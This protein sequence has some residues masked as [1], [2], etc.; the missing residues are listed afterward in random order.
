MGPETDE[1]RRFREVEDAFLAVTERPEGEREG[2]LEGLDPAVREEVRRLLEAHDRGGRIPKDPR[3]TAFAAAMR[4]A[5]DAVDDA[6]DEVPARVGPYRVVRRIGRGGMGTVFEAEEDAPRRRVAVK[7]LRAGI[8][9]EEARRRFALEAQALARLSHPG[10]ARIYAMGTADESQGGRPWIAMELVTGRSILEH[11]RAAGLSVKARLGL[12]AAVADAVAHAHRKGV[13]HRDLKPGNVLVDEQG[14]PKVLDFGVARVL[15]PDG[16]TE[17]LHTAAGAL[18]GTVAYMSPE[19]CLGRADAIDTRSDVYALGALAYELLGGRPPHDVDDLAL[20]AAVREVAETDPPTLGAVLPTLKGDVSIL[21]AKAM[22]REP[23][24]RYAGADAFA[25]DVRRWLRE[26]PILARS[27]TAGY[28]IRKFVGR[29][30]ELAVGLAAAVLALVAGLVVA[31][32][33]GREE[34]RQ[35]VRADLVSTDA[36]RTRYRA[37][38]AAAAAALQSHDPVAARRRLE[39]VPADRR[40]WEWDWLWAQTDPA[41]THAAPAVD[42]KAVVSLDEDG[43]AVTGVTPAGEVVRLDAADGKRS[44]P[45]WPAGAASSVSGEGARVVAIGDDGRVRLLED[46]GRVREAAGIAPTRAR[47]SAGRSPDGTRLVVVHGDERTAGPLEVVDA[48]TG[49][50]VAT[51]SEPAFGTVLVR[52]SRDGRLVAT[53]G[54]ADNRLHVWEVETGRHVRA[55]VGHGQGVG[56]AAFSRDGRLVATGSDDHTAAVFAVDSGEMVVRLFGHT[57]PLTSVAWSPDEREVATAARD[58]TVRRY[59]ARRGEL[60]DTFLAGDVGDVL[61]VAW[62]AAGARIVAAGPRSIRAFRVRGGPPAVLRAHAGVDDGNPYPYVYG[63]AWSP[64]GRRVASAGWDGTAR[65][66]LAAT[67][68]LLA[69]FRSEDLPGADPAG[70]HPPYGRPAYGVAFSPDGGR[71]AVGTDASLVVYD[72]DTAEVLAARRTPV[73]GPGFGTRAPTAWS[74]DG[75]LLL[76]TDVG[77]VTQVADAA[78]LSPRWTAAFPPDVYGHGGGWSPDGT[79]VALAMSNGE[80]RVL[81]AEGG[82]EVLRVPA[83]EAR[84]GAERVANDALYVDGGRAIA[85][86]YADAAIRLFDATTGAL[87]ST[88]RGHAGAVHGLFASPDGLR[89]FSGSADGSIRV[90]DLEGAGDEVLS[91]GGHLSY[92]FS[93]ALS[94]DGHTLASGSGD[95]TVRL[96]STR[97]MWS[98]M[99]DARVAWRLRELLEGDAVDPTPASI[100]LARGLKMLSPKDLVR[101]ARAEEPLVGSHGAL[102]DWVLRHSPVGPR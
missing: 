86:S 22:A 41:A 49:A 24:R 63:V 42:L 4:E 58:G 35:R 91:M 37:E 36:V 67:G 55:I 72:A 100:T 39:L 1:A 66:C 16:G 51:G 46:G 54:P 83:P 14:Q 45:S 65:V 2:A 8:A 74:P 33:L 89:L 101:R 11:C 7:L 34:Q 21:V 95:G 5:L 26:E 84:P 30:K 13:I 53:A 98:R 25:D 15:A 9:A 80:C 76:T 27:P 19:Q 59:D 90:W 50:R 64:D 17:S 56:A 23:D 60:L 102:L 69:T 12:V 61:R 93:V 79:R 10:I 48:R 71:L 57:A 92:V 88:L 68:E 97:D 94:P 3:P 78:T 75:R 87:R 6:D 43:A 28:Q 47:V 96:W 70:R 29:H 31:I 52:F 85:V 77:H 20:P 38:V 99:E 40:R 73:D 44:G 62:D 18:V 32:V 82:R 81:A